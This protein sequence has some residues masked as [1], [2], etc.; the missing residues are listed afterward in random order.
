MKPIFSFTSIGLA[1]HKNSLNVLHATFEKYTLRI[2]L[3]IAVIVS[4]IYFIIFLQN[5]LG[6]AYNDARS[7]LDIGRRVVEGLKPGFAQLGS[8]WLPLPHVLMLPFVWHDDL[9]HT[10][11]AGALPSMVSF[12]ALVYLIYMFLKRLG[13]GLLGRIAG[14]FVFMANLN[15]LYLQSTAMTELLS[16]ATMT[17]AMYEFL[18][19]HKNGNIFNFVKCSFFIMLAT[20]TR[21]DA[22]FL[23][24]FTAGIIVVET[25]LR[26]GFKRM[27]GKIILF[28][29]MGGFGI[30]LWLL[31]NQAIFGDPL[32]FAFG[33]YSAHSQQ[34]QLED[35][36]VLDTKG[37]LPLSLIIYLYAMLYNVGGFTLFLGLV[38]G[39]LLFF[40]KKISS[41]MRI[42][43]LTLISP[44]IFNILA[45]FLGHS[46][47]FIQ[48]ISGNT[49]FNVRYGVMVIP[50]VA[51]FV[52]YLVH[53]AQPAFRTALIGL[54]LFVTF[55]MFS[56]QDAVTID[57]A[58]IGASQ[59]N[60]VEVSSWLSDNARDKEGFVLIS[61][62]SHD[63]IIFSSG[64]PMKKFI[65][66][67]TGEYWEQAIKDPD[68]WARWIIMRTTDENDQTWRLVRDTEGFKRYR[69]VHSYPF[70][71]IFELEPEY[72]PSVRKTPTEEK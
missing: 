17:A 2:L 9:W 65:H 16:L 39:I 58:T 8:V 3:I 33:Q 69:K 71:D 28:C 38:G 18:Q 26:K 50:S 1:L 64:L 43:S 32:Y 67:G 6:L 30:F 14:V 54:M 24:A 44:L 12:V 20:L 41:S 34:S 29:T 70:A 7:H 55:F 48:G 42:A 66:E 27:E 51:I 61:A 37:N 31:W 15:V 11:L 4:V 22:W 62:A 46:V 52:G 63:A 25:F 57:D 45:L 10:G 35:A 60:V 40:D 36:G 47:V 72:V 21:Y 23:F 56:S 13:V 19:W 5:G 68:R 53:K 59:K 49:W